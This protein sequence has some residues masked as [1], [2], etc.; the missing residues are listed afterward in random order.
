[1]SSLNP[2]LTVATMLTEPMKV[3]GIGGSQK[4]RLSIAGDLLDQVQLPEDALWRY[5]HEFSGGQRQRI[6]IA[7]ALV[8]NP[9]LIVCDEVTS[10]LD[11]SVQGEILQLLLR[12][13]HERGLALL[14][15]THDI[16]VVEYISDRTVVMYHGKVVESGSTQQVC[17]APKDSYT[18]TLLAA[19]PRLN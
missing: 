19:V 8:L 12:L 14:F 15:I 16:A 6:G 17:S 9:K 18:K 11:V 1:M 10:A 3:H 2:R 7:R 5:P 13:R 4:E